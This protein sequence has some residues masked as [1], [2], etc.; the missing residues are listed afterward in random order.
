MNE[1]EQN[2][3]PDFYQLNLSYTLANQQI[4]RALQPS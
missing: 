2:A 3:K 4:A 1:N